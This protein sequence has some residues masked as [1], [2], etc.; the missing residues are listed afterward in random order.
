VFTRVA[1]ESDG[2]TFIKVDVDA[3]P[4][5]AT[6]YGVT[7]IPTTLAF[8]GGVEVARVS[9]MLKYDDLTD[10]VNDVCD[11]SVAGGNGV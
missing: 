7:A 5:I 4:L 6:A 9:G 3:Q 2:V 8:T 11:F 1:S 10:V